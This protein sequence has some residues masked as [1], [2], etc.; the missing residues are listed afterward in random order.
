MVVKAASGV[1]V[2]APMRVVMGRTS[3][4]V[5]FSGLPWYLTLNPPG[6]MHKIEALQAVASGES[7]AFARAADRG[8]ARYLKEHSRG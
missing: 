7:E 3:A 2:V 1:T 8:L 6:A 5:R 4:R